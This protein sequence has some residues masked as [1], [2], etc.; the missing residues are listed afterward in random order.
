MSRTKVIAYQST[1]I[2]PKENECFLLAESKEITV[3]KLSQIF[4]CFLFILNISLKL[5]TQCNRNDENNENRFSVK[6]HYKY[7]V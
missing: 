4:I 7:H 2:I 1:V 6:S 5:L 3:E